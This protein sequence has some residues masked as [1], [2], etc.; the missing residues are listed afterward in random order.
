MITLTETE[1]GNQVFDVANDDRGRVVINGVE[2]PGCRRCCP[3]EGWADIMLYPGGG[4]DPL[5]NEAGDDVFVVRILAERTSINFI[6]FTEPKETS[7]HG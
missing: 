1:K 3:A 2:I 4:G 6:E 7:S 5:L